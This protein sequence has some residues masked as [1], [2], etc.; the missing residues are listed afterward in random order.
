MDRPILNDSVD[1]GGMWCGMVVVMASSMLIMEVKWWNLAMS[2][3]LCGT[4]FVEL[5]RSLLWWITV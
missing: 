5:G 4:C 1:I 2:V 3:G